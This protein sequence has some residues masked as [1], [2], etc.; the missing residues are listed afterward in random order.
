MRCRV[1]IALAVLL[2]CVPALVQAAMIL[3]PPAELDAGA[4]VILSGTVTASNSSWDDFRRAIHTDVA[5]TTDRYDK[6]SGPLEIVLR[7][8]GG[9]VGDIGMLVEDFP[10]FTIGDHVTLHLTS[11]NEPA[12]YRLHGA[13][14]G[15]SGAGVDARGGKK[16]RTPKLYSYSGHHR[17]PASCHYHTNTGLP[18]DWTTA[19]QN[20]TG[21]W[22]AAGS[23][24][25]FHY[26]GTT[27]RSGPEYDG[28]NVV[29]RTNMGSGGILAQN[30]Y[31]YLRRGKLV[32][33]NDIVFNTYYP[34]ST[35]GNPS[36]YDVQGIATHELGHSLVLNDLYKSFQSEMTMY[37]YAGIGETKKRT[38]ESGDRDGIVRI[39]GAGDAGAVTPVTAPAAV[40]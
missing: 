10:T 16:P 29:T 34:W 14:Q 3:L 37:G 5:V 33:E 24:F 36:A 6:G 18:G 35:D 4:D 25:R 2:A 8:P 17:E 28:T 19:I 30:T 39:Y 32:L 1:A 11:T 20:G 12:V 22:N 38:L 7:V 13:W 9:E 26:S 15:V 21:A 23:A 31:W 40:D 27:S